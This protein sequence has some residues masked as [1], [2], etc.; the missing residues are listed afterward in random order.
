MYAADVQLDAI[1]AEG[2]ENR[3]T[4]HLEMRSMT[5]QWADSRGFGVFADRPYASPTVT[6]VDNR[7]KNVDV[8]EMAKFMSGKYF[9]LD[10]GYGQIKGKT[11]RIAHMGDLTLST[12]EEFL[13]GLDEFLGV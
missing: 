8:D 12:L 13:S 7:A 3:W 9:T 10:K 4:R 2:L 5:H 6:A 11:F 1:H